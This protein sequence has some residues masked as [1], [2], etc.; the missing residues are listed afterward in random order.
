[1]KKVLVVG[2]FMKGSGLTNYLIDIY[3]NLP[4]KDFEVS[5]LSYSSQHNIDY[6][7]KELQWKK[8]EVT[9]I[10]KNPFEHF[11]NWSFFFKSHKNEFDEIHF[12]YSASWNFFAILQAK[13]KTKS[14]IIVQSHNNYFS[15]KPKGIQKVILSFLNA[16]GRVVINK[17]ADEKLAV[18]IDSSKWMFGSTKTV[19]ILKNGIDLDKFKY[20][21]EERKRLRKS[22]NIKE[23]QKLVGF[24][25]T[26]EARK[27]PRFAIE[28][29]KRLD[30]KFILC[31]FGQ[32]MLEESL[33][34]KIKDENLDKRVKLMGVSD[35]LN[36]WYSAFDIFLFPSITEGFGFALLEA[37]A[38]GLKCISSNSIPDDAKLTDDVL[39][40]DLKSID[41]WIKN[42]KNITV[43]DNRIN[44][45]NRNC[46][47]I[48]QKGYSIES[49]SMCFKEI[50]GGSS[51]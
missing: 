51:I 18:S 34:K 19:K 32:G 3:K 22:I 28:C 46:Q 12:N 45:S 43:L 26:L 20:D 29:I 31:I 25:G 21:P 9:S 49:T 14:K 5:C 16:I 33:R 47:I 7:L 15:K 11:K 42:I 44:K 8:Y 35:D 39:S 27:N 40:L 6:L 10:N 30:S 50:L 23:S 24:V 48:S 36:K 37:Q 41:I 1:M 4:Q 13:I 17:C 38:S 2:D